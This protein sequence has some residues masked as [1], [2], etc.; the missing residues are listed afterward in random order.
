MNSVSP[1]LAVPALLPPQRHGERTPQPDADALDGALAQV[2]RVGA[3]DS[4]RDARDYATAP[5]H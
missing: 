3:A 1:S 4:A 2:E 5:T